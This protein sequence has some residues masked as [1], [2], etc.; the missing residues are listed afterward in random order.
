MLD[1]DLIIKLFTIIRPD[2]VVKV[3]RKYHFWH[4]VPVEVGE[5]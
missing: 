3:I 4:R 2:V 1:H 5:Q